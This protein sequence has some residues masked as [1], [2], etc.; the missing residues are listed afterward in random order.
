MYQT[1][2][3]FTF[4]ILI[5][6]YFQ[7]KTMHEEEDQWFFN[8]YIGLLFPFL[9]VRIFIISVRYATTP[10]QLYVEQTCEL[11]SEDDINKN[12]IANAWVNIGPD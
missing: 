12:L 7:N 8:C 5:Y 11:L 10:V 9:I 6:L 1:V 2:Y 4:W 3:W